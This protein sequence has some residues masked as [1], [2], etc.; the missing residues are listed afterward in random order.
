MRLTR[1]GQMALSKNMPRSF[2][3]VRS[4]GLTRSVDMVLSNSTARSMITVPSW[5]MTHSFFV[6][7]FHIILFLISKDIKVLFNK[8][9]YNIHVFIYDTKLIMKESEKEKI[10]EEYYK[11]TNQTKRRKVLMAPQPVTLNFNG[12]K[13]ESG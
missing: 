12:L 9:I 5:R 7:F 6:V 3:M 13:I 1:S 4:M 11:L 8:V 2:D 10:L